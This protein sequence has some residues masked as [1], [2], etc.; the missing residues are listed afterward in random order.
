MDQLGQI[1]DASLIDQQVIL[2][3]RKLKDRP[4]KGMRYVPRD[5]T[6]VSIM[7][8]LSG[9]GIQEAVI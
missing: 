3:H 1:S 5:G 2:F 6:S 9:P 8:Q 4:Q 7:R